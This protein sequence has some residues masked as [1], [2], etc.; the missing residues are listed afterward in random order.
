MNPELRELHLV[1]GETRRLTCWAHGEGGKVEGLGTGA[2]W[3]VTAP[4]VCRLAGAGAV[5]VVEA[6]APGGATVSVRH[7]TVLD[8][9]EHVTVRE[10]LWEGR[11]DTANWGPHARRRPDATVERS[12]PRLKKVERTLTDYIR[13]IVHDPGEAAPTPRVITIG[14]EG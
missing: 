7:A 1:V 10:V 11:A 2:S 4:Q 9:V 5:V 8:D 13:V 12:E 14:V 6:L 3:S